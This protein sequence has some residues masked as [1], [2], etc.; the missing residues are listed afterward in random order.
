MNE[1][2]FENDLENASADPRRDPY[3][4]PVRPECGAVDVTGGR[5]VMGDHSPEGEKGSSNGHMCSRS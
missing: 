2:I 3:R 5:S 4:C 1:I